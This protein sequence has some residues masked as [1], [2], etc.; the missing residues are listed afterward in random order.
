M[1]ISSLAE[2]TM[3][4]L[5]FSKLPTIQP[6]VN[7]NHRPATVTP[8]IAHASEKPTT[9]QLS[10]TLVHATNEISPTNSSMLGKEDSDDDGLL[11]PLLGQSHN[12]LPRFR[13][14]SNPTIR[15]NTLYGSKVRHKSAEGC[16][17]KRTFTTAF[18]TQY[19]TSQRLD[20]SV[21]RRRLQDQDVTAPDAVNEE[22][23]V[24][25]NLNTGSPPVIP[26]VHIDVSNNQPKRKV[27]QAKLRDYY[28]DKRPRME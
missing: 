27:T 8:S 19:T 5:P 16:G 14:G 1:L 28:R 24:V 11:S 3:E 13:V 25:E 10:S 21:Q 18:D 17:I 4:E 2:A 6:M 23:V 22:E 20:T 12:P 7:T 9:K 26:H 15:R